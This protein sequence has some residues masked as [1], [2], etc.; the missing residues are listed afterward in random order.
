[1]TLAFPRD[2]PCPC[3]GPTASLELARGEY[4]N[5]QLVALPYGTGLE[6]AEVKVAGISGPQGG[7]GLDVSVHPVGSLN[8]AP[9]A[10]WR[11]AAG[12]DFRP[13]VYQSWT[14]DP[15]LTDR[16]AVDVAG[17]DLQP[18][19][20]QIRSGRAARLGRHHRRPAATA[21][22]DREQPH[23]LGRGVRHQ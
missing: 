15:I 23:G 7:D 4:E 1:M 11:P 3:G 18:F 6:D 12:T 5:V 10:E 13:A 20:V 8:I 2:L 14:P 19:W 16:T 17:D 9:P 22:G 21:H